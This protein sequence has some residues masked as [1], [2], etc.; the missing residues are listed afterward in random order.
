MFIA[1]VVAGAA[2][3]VLGLLIGWALW[4]GAAAGTCPVPATSVP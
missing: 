4:H 3:I 1:V 2:G